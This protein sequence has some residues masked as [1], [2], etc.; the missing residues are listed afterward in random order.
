MPLVE[1]IECGASVSPTAHTCPQCQRAPG[2]ETCILCKGIIKI[3]DAYRITA[4]DRLDSRPTAK[5]TRADKFAHKSC[6]VA[7]FPDAEAPC[8]DCGGPINIRSF[9]LASGPG[10]L[11][12]GDPEQARWY[13]FTDRGWKREDPAGPAAARSCPQCGSTTVLS[14]GD[15]FSSNC[16]H[17]HLPVL[18]THAAAE[19]P[20]TGLWIHDGCIDGRTVDVD[21]EGEQSVKRQELGSEAPVRVK[22]SR[23]LLS[24]A[25]L[26]ACLAAGC[27]MAFLLHS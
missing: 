4:W 1:C 3:E 7:L 6:V 26:L 22:I 10:L 23:V 17:C 20:R 24:L 11:T 15:R 8:A 2:G 19:D 25:T 9:G 21:M 16:R 12:V 13:G 18:T 5:P 14:R 27:L